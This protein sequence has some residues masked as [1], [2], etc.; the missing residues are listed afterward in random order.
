VRLLLD[1]NVLLDVALKRPPFVTD[2]ALVL[3]AIDLGRAQGFIAAHT[4]TTAFYI[5]A[6]NAGFQDAMTGVAELLPMLDVVPADRAD[7]SQALALGWRDFEDAV[8]SVSATK[9]GA[10]FIVT[11]DLHD[12]HGSSVPAR[13]PSFVLPL[14]K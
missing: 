14:L 5:I 13:E 12:F 6:K 11:R 7:L 8:Q 3:N 1:I 2:A 4:V 9:V 10:D